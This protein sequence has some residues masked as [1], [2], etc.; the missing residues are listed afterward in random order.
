VN[1]DF[2]MKF[3]KRAKKF[4]DKAQVPY[5]L[6]GF[7]SK[8]AKGTKLTLFLFK[9]EWSGLAEVEPVAFDDN[10]TNL[11]VNLLFLEA[12]LAAALQKFPKDRVVRGTPQVYLRSRELAKKAAEPPPPAITKK[13]PEVVEE[14]VKPPP[15]EEVKVEPTKSEPVKE[16]PVKPVRVTPTLAESQPDLPS[17]TE[18]AKPDEDLGELWSIF[19]GD[20]GDDSGAIVGPAIPIDNGRKRKRDDGS[21]VGKWWFWTGVGAGVLLLG[22]GATWVGLEYAGGGESGYGGHLVYQP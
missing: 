6:F 21:I 2:K 17:R 20:G 7:V 12:N 9:A 14:P 8:E 3:S 18:P 19:S 5:L 10:L 22:G 4:A 15:R 13:E 1:G 16:E 11:Q